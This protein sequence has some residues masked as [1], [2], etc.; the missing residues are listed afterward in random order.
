FKLCK[1]ENFVIFVTFKLNLFEGW[2]YKFLSMMIVNTPATIFLQ[3]KIFVFVFVTK[4]VI[5][6][7][8]YFFT[9]VVYKSPFTS[10]VFD[11]IY[12]FILRKNFLVEKR[13]NQFP[14]SIYNS[15]Q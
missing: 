6:I 1:G 11:W 3:D 15:S 13:N 14:F 2:F 4:I 10:L 9:V 5:D 8:E 12:M 7:G